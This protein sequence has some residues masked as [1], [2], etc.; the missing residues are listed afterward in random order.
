V[1]GDPSF[2]RNDGTAQPRKAFVSLNV[3][4]VII[5]SASL[6]MH[7]VPITDLNYAC[8]LDQAN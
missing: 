5:W 1:D 4:A 2:V 7:P 3:N 8:K 6:P